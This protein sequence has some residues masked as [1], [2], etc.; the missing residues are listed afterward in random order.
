MSGF[1]G[2]LEGLEVGSDGVLEGVEVK[3]GR[4]GRGAVEDVGVDGFVVGPD[5]VVAEG[6]DLSLQACRKG[7]EIR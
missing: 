6:V 3:F 7:K 2:G 1:G 5:L 4:R